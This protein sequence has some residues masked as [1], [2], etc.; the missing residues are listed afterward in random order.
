LPRVFPYDAHGKEITMLPSVLL[1]HATKYGST[2]ELAAIRT[3]ATNPVAR[4]QPVQV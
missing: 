4:L 1:A 2:Q 3:W